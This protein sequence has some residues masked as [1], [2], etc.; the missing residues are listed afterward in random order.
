[1]GVTPSVEEWRGPGVTCHFFIINYGEWEGA[2]DNTQH[3]RGKVENERVIFLRMCCE[4]SS[5]SVCRAISLIV[6]YILS[7]Y[8]PSV[9]CIL[10]IWWI[11]MEPGREQGTNH[12]NLAFTL[13]G[14]KIYCSNFP[15]REFEHFLCF[16][17][18]FFCKNTLRLDERGTTNV[19]DIY[20]S[21]LAFLW[22][23]FFMI[24]RFRSEE[25]QFIEAGIWLET[26]DT[27]NFTLLHVAILSNCWLYNVN[28][29]I[30]FWQYSR[31]RKQPHD[32]SFFV[33]FILKRK[34]NETTTEKV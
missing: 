19:K 27:F 13:Y 8:C 33:G 3:I 11:N 12:F 34:E 25:I 23:C 1:M 22:F 2:C 24:C 14:H 5:A 31:K 4:P 10:R 6:K 7:Q 16:Y 17:Y 26:H 29:A 30:N 32:F 28:I 9:F 15:R 21:V 18:N 20:F